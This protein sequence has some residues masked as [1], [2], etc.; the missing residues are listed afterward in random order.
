MSKYKYYFKKPKG[1]IVKDI[2]YGLMVGGMVVI[3]ATSPY[4]A[5]NVVRAF[6][7]RKQYKKRSFM[8]AFYR[9]K[10]QGLLEISQKNHQIYISLT[11]EGRKKA[12]MLQVNHLKIKRAK[13]WDKKWRVVIFDISELTRI[14]RDGFRGF[15][16]MLGFYPFQQSV[17]VQPYDCKDEVELLRDFF[18]LTKREVN[19]LVVEH[20]EDDIV[21]RKKFG[22]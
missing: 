1:E 22:V 8:N 15:L 2:L 5:V 20:L 18:G 12:G 4:F 9:L 21:L 13:T 19:L 7:K 6:Q 16:K 11:D 17:W 10:K 14:K 3:A